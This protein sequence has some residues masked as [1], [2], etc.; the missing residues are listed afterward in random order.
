MLLS[1]DQPA[2]GAMI[3]TI[4]W[5]FCQQ[6]ATLAISK[7]GQHRQLQFRLFYDAMSQTLKFGYLAGAS[8]QIGWNGTICQLPMGAWLPVGEIAFTHILCGQDLHPD[9]TVETNWTSQDG[10]VSLLLLRKL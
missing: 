4:Y 1:L 6:I 2:D 7:V 10:L 9:F 5:D 8:A 3:E